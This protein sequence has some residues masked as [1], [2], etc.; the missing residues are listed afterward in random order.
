[1][2]RDRLLDIGF[3]FLQ[4]GSL[5]ALWT[6][7]DLPGLVLLGLATAVG[8]IGMQRGKKANIA[9]TPDEDPRGRDPDA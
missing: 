2:T 1:M 5:V 7:A 8:L 6:G 3:G 4:G 9:E